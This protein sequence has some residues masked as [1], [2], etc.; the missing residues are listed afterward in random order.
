MLVSHIYKFIYIKSKKTA[1]SSTEALLEQFCI[2]PLLTKEWK[3]S[4]SRD[5]E[6]TEYGI[7]GSRWGGTTTK[8]HA[9]M[10][11]SSIYNSLGQ[12]I[13]DK[14]TKI[15][16]IRNP[17]DSVISQ[18][19]FE[20]GS[21]I[22]A[23]KLQ[24]PNINNVEEFRNWLKYNKEEV[25]SNRF[26]WSSNGIKDKNEYSKDNY[27]FKYIKYENLK[28]DIISLASEL[29]LELD[30]SL[31]PHYKK[32]YNKLNTLENRNYYYDKESK[33]FIKKHFEKEL[34]VFSY[35]FETL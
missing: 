11:C 3:P 16:N 23:E 33:D 24:K 15:C 20:R 34:E 7:I 29:N 14:Y 10:E 26:L 12:E 22:F 8:Y 17:Y 6:Q 1:G 31:L 30:I 32:S 9:H 5:E 21:C 28:N 27:N 2:N 35:N 18:F 13:W 25:I 4:H 19:R